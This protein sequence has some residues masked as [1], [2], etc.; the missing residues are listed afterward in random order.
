MYPTLFPS[1]RR[2]N[3]HSIND[4]PSAYTLQALLE[5]YGTYITLQE[6]LEENNKGRG[7]IAK[8]DISPGTILIQETAFVWQMDNNH[9]LRWKKDLYTN[10]LS[11]SLDEGLLSASSSSSGDFSSFSDVSSSS[12]DSHLINTSIADALLYQ[13]APYA[14]TNEILMRIRLRPINEKEVIENT[15]K[16]NSFRIVPLPLNTDDEEEQKK[17]NVER[18]EEKEEEEEGRALFSIICLTN[19][20]CRPNS[21]VYQSYGNNNT[22]DKHTKTGTLTP[23]SPPQ[24]TLETRL[25]ITEGEE[26]TIAYLPRAWDKVKRQQ[27]IQ[28]QWNFECNCERCSLPWDD[29]YAAKCS[30]CTD[31]FIYGGA[32]NCSVCGETIEQV[33]ME[34]LLGGTMVPLPF[35][36]GEEEVKLTS[37]SS[38]EDPGPTTS[39]T[40]SHR[41]STYPNPLDTLLSSPLPIDKLVYELIHHPLLAYHDIRLFTA[42]NQLLPLLTEEIEGMEKEKEITSTT[43][44]GKNLDND[45]SNQLYRKLY[46]DTVQILVQGALQSSYT[47]PE[48]L[49]IEIDRSGSTEDTGEE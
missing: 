43:S 40:G 19:H 38:S 45:D 2:T 15:M 4:C 34:Q 11:S 5:P 32:L 1:D 16:A 10:D 8:Q 31:G 21:K 13:M 28:S 37:S 49:G 14:Y 7:L 23:L 24:Y 9:E 29:V 20:S 25:P 36:M 26:I 12:T 22:N 35:S 6:T 44:K 27:Y 17:Q 30:Y 39:T 47:S 41:Y 46:Q 48:D 42:L 18:K 3:P 33:R